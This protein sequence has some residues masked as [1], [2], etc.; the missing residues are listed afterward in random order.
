MDEPDNRIRVGIREAAEM[1]GISKRMLEYR[2]AQK[3]I[4]IVR[5]GGRSLVELTELRRYARS[6]RL[7]SPRVKPDNA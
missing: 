2:I 3:E 6:N 7:F 4:R 5:D 1:V